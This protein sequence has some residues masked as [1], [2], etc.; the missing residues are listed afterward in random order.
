MEVIDSR[1]SLKVVEHLGGKTVQ[2]RGTEKTELLRILWKLCQ[3]GIE[4]MHWMHW[5]ENSISSSVEKTEPL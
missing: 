1:R 5:R 2:R 4:R 3:E